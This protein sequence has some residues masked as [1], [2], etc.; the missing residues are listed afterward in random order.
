VPAWRPPERVAV[1]PFAGR[2]P[3]GQRVPLE[4]AKLEGGWPVVSFADTARAAAEAASPRPFALRGLVA[5]LRN[6]MRSCGV[7]CSTSPRR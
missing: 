6:S 2:Q 4:P 3:D 7:T 1:K 5:K